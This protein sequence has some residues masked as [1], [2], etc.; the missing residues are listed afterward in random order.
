MTSDR[1]GGNMEKVIVTRPMIGI[2]H[3]QVCADKGVSEEEVLRE[4]NRQ[5]PS[6]T[7]NGW[8]RIERD[9]SMAPVACADDPNRMH[10]MIVC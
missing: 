2:C 5:N 9:G 6:G 3:M 7:M 8:S 10:Y 1:K 4:A